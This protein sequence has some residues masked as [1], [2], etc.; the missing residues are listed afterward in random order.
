[1]TETSGGLAYD[2]MPLPG[3][4]FR[5]DEATG[6]IEVTGPMLARGY[7]GDDAATAEAFVDGWHRTLDAGRIV[8]GRLEVLGRLDDVVQVGG[9]NVAV[10]A[11]EDVLLDVCDDACVLV[12]ADERW[13][14]RLTAYVVGTAPD[15]A[16]A[17]LVAD[18]LGRPAVPRAWVR[19]PA[20]PH[21]PNGKPDRDTLRARSR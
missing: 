19:L 14:A 9:V 17:A 15:E 1:M 5:I 12:A 2:G 3:A 18:A 20:I 10:A 21:L 16:L 13:G 6:R 8:D 11:V 7:L 4:A